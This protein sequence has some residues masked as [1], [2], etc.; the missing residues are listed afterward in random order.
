[1]TPP[2]KPTVAVPADSV[3]PTTQTTPELI[4][5]QTKA[6]DAEARAIAAEEREKRALADYQNL[7]RRSQEDRMRTIKLAGMEFASVLL[8]PLDNLS[9]AAAQLKDAGLN[10]VVGQFEQALAQA[11]L[12]EIK[13]MDQKFDVNTMEVVETKAKG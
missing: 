5:L 11:G 7:V 10:M 2:Q 12:E 3:P 13:G 6:S 1:M 4:A 8:Q 9:R